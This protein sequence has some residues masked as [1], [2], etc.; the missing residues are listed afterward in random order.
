M[1]RTTILLALLLLAAAC[2]P[3]QI[4]EG[5]QVFETSCAVGYCHGLDG[6]PGRGPR[7]RD[8]VWS[9][10]YL[11][12]TIEKGIPGSPMPAWEGK[13]TRPQIDALV[14][15][16]LSISKEQPDAAPVPLP[17]ANHSEATDLLP[18]KALFFDPMRDRNCGACHRVAGSG[19]EVA[20]LF[21]GGQIL[22]QQITSQPDSAENTKV[23]L[24]DG[25]EFCGIKAAEDQK[26]LRI[27]DVGG[28]GPPVLRTLSKSEILSQTGCAEF[29]A[30]RDNSTVYTA[31]ELAEIAA[32]LGASVRPK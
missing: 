24:R 23:S 10:S 12:Q 17:A 7:L 32:F 2:L 8:R 29:N 1:P 25:E 4:T 15:Y 16:I 27:Y 26:T 19:T 5:K 11:Y 21:A 30:H 6:R 9:K 14:I 20:P 28:T 31:E 13:L 18:G 3:A 22:L